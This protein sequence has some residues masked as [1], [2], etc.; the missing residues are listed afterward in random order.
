MTALL[1]VLGGLV[2]A[3]TRYLTDQWVQTRRDSIVPWGTFVVNVTGSFILGLVAGAAYGAGLPSWALTLVGTGFC[4]ALTTF[5]TFGYET[6]RLIETGNYRAA[7]FNV[8]TSLAA[9]L[10]ASALGWVIGTAL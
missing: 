1:V 8:V 10:A 2:G 9:G 3:P 6:W 7:T 4:G 5:S